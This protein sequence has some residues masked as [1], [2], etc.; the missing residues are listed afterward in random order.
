MISC[1]LEG[2]KLSGTQVRANF[3]DLET[4]S[5]T[6]DKIYYPPPIST[7]D[8]EPLDNQAKKRRTPPRSCSYRVHDFQY[9]VQKSACHSGTDLASLPALKDGLSPKKHCVISLKRIKS[10]TRVGP[11]RDSKKKGLPESPVNP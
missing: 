7:I 5:R 3:M 10:G 6:A 4:Y 11:G 8:M 1:G 9:R 2:E